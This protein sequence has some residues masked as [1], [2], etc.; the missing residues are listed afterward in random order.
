MPLG[1]WLTFIVCPLGFYKSAALN[2]LECVYNSFSKG[3]TWEGHHWVSR[4][5]SSTLLKKVE[6]L[7]KWSTHVMSSGSSMVTIPPGSGQ[8][9]SPEILPRSL[10]PLPSFSQD[11]VLQ[12]LAMASGI[13]SL[14]PTLNRP[15]DEKPRP[16]CYENISSDP[17]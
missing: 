16:H 3:Q 13:V 10:H 8:S 9:A 6:R 5:A 14:G 7:S 1:L 11:Y 12:V 2:I 17:G 4:H 15:S